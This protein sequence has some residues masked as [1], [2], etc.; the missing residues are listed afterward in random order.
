VT[1]DRPPAA[2]L[3]T[4]DEDQREGRLQ[5]TY[6]P[7]P[8]WEHIDFNLDVPQL[9]DIRLRRAIALGAN[10][11]AMVDTLFGG[12]SPVLGSWV[13][14]GQAEAAPPEQITRYEY[15]PDEA[16]KLLDEAGYVDQD[17]DGIRASPDGLTLTFQLLTTDGNAV[18]QQI[19]DMFRNDMRALGVDIQ[20][21]PVPAD[22]LFS[23]DGPL[24]QRQFDLAL[25]G[26]IASPDPGGLL[27]WSCVAVPSPENNWSGDNFAG[28]CFRDADRA[29]REAATTLDLAQRQAAYLRQQQLWAQELPSL[30]LFQ[31]LSVALVV[32]GVRGTQ[33]DALA[34]IT[35]NIASWKRH[36]S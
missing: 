31:R 27:L 17:G 32:P 7:N 22:Q 30:P 36:K 9:Q 8:I 6:L 3:A 21:L 34:P 35:W 28:W 25:F 13:L 19:A 26:W 11:Q 29:I 16:R 4:F 33:L 5:V 15:N 1:T 10:R 24:F 23:P 20:P 12:H 18:R 14:P 2:Q